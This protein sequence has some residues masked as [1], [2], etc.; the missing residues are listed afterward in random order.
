MRFSFCFN[1][2]FVL[3]KQSVWLLFNRYTSK[4][5]TKKYWVAFC[6]RIIAKM[7][8]KPTQTYTTCFRDIEDHMQKLGTLRKTFFFSPKLSLCTVSHIPH[9]LI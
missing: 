5:A 3:C 6:I 1:F 9:Q 4:D 2:D 7:K 8:Q